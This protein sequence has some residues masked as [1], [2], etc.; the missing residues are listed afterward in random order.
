MHRIQNLYGMSIALFVICVG[1]ITAQQWQHTYGI[2]TGVTAGMVCYEVGQ[3][4]VQR[5]S[6][7]GYIAAGYHIKTCISGGTRYPQT[8]VYVVRTDNNGAIIWSYFYNIQ[9]Y[10]EGYDIR[11]CTNGDF[12]ITGRTATSDGECRNGN[13]NLYDILLMR[14][15]ANGVPLWAKKYGTIDSNEAGNALLEATVGNGLPIGTPGATAPGD[16]VIAGD[17]G[18]SAILMRTDN[19]GNLIWDRKYRPDSTSECIFHDVEEAQ[20]PTVGDI[21]AGGSAKYA[22]MRRIEAFAVRVDENSGIIGAA[23]QGSLC[24]GDTL[25]EVIYG[26]TEDIVSPVPGT[27]VT[28]GKTNSPSPGSTSTNDEILVMGLNGDFTTAGTSSIQIYGDNGSNSD[29]GYDIKQI[30]SAL[31]NT[32]NYILTGYV[33]SSAGFGGKDVFLLEITPALVPPTA[34]TFVPFTLYGGSK[35]DIG[36]S[37]NETTGGFTTPGF[38]A[39]G[40]ANGPLGGGNTN[41]KQ[42]YMIKTDAVGIS[43]CY[44]H[45]LPDTTIHRRWIKEFVDPVLE[46]CLVESE[47]R[48]STIEWLHDVELCLTGSVTPL[49]KN[50]RNSAIP[51]KLPEIQLYQNTLLNQ[52]PIRISATVHSSTQ[53]IIRVIDIN[54]NSLIQESFECDPGVSILD[55][56]TSNLPSGRYEVVMESLGNIKSESLIITK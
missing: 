30:Q 55:L 45:P 51:S 28:T 12:I 16:I 14:I 46:P 6:T 47:I 15:T 9:C 44:E 5:V 50:N 26:L 36:H 35:D 32:G 40:I 11:E 38:I 52:E 8:D 34:G 31:L 17:A 7:G 54:G 4:G 27:I 18:L 23:P 21:I 39:C 1:T 22:N 20:F 24:V 10:D 33:Q 43:G 19:N 49:P 56:S 41:D 42:L 3:K 25:D 2:P 48:I 13:P 37:V 29:V 53:L